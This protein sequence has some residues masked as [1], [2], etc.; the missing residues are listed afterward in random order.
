VWKCANVEIF[1]CGNVEM[2]ISVINQKGG[3]GKTTLATNIA[4]G[5]VFRGARVVIA[6]S[7]P[8]GSAR[9]WVAA[10]G[11]SKVSVMG[12]DRVGALSQGLKSLANDYDVVIV[13]GAPSV[14][15]LAA[16]AIKSSDLV[17]IPVQP[18]PYDIW[19]VATIVEMVKA[20]Q[21]LL[22]KPNAFFVISRAIPNT[23]LA[24]ELEHALKEY[25]FDVC[26]GTTQRQ[27]YVKSAALGQSDYDFDDKNAI[28]EIDFILD[29]VESKI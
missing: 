27:V 28:E 24:R 5:I 29:F 1:K 14:D 11:D 22:D 3:A 6:D 23:I 21:A 26:K 10:N 8:Q 9:D 7:D 2:I 15:Q 19:A 18:S 13:D 16:E 17:L 12:L 25:G 4:S 20:R